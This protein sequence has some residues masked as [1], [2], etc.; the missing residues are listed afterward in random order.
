MA[1]KSFHGWFVHCHFQWMSKTEGPLQDITQLDW[2][3]VQGNQAQK[4]RIKR[5]VLHLTK[6]EGGFNLPDLELY[7]LPTQGFYLRHC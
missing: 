7:Q 6:S 4:L 3:I 2:A 1:E 5:K